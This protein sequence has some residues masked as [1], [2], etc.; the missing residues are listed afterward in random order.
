LSECPVMGSRRWRWRTRSMPFQ[1]TS[2]GELGQRWG[3]CAQ[4]CVFFFCFFF[5]CKCFLLG[6]SF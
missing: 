2:W 4:A 5:V 3:V 6:I 1:R